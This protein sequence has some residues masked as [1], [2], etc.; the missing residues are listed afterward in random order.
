[1]R[2]EPILA[3]S[4][5]EGD[6]S[7]RNFPS[8]TTLTQWEAPWPEFLSHSVFN[9]HHKMF[10]AKSWPARICLLS[11]KYFLVGANHT[12]QDIFFGRT[13]HILEIVHF[14]ESDP[15]Y[16]S[17]HLLKKSL[18]C[19]G[20]GRLLFNSLKTIDLTF[21]RNS[22]SKK[23]CLADSPK[24]LQRMHLKGASIP[25]HFRLSIVKIWLWTKTQLKTSI[26][27]RLYGQREGR[28]IW[29]RASHTLLSPSSF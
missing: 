11:F 24:D 6:F 5:T 7:R 22:Q 17:C 8:N 19:R 21:C 12:C 10:D 18:N 3:Y 13:F 16:S 9:L 2:G 14:L 4:W 26:F 25:L 28:E 20:R 27:G 23:R 1:M 29:T 15:G